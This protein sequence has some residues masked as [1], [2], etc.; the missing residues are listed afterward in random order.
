MSPELTA[1]YDR[2]QTTVR[3][4]LC[5]R[6]SFPQF[7][8]AHHADGEVVPYLPSDEFESDKEALAELLRTLLA[9]ARQGLITA[10]VLVVPVSAFHPDAPFASAMFDLEQRGFPRLLSLHH[11]AVLESSV[12]LRDRTFQPAEPRLFAP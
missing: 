12:E 7:A 10:N 8:V 1:A 11:Y 9:G 4:Y 3:N 2:A 5:S 6:K